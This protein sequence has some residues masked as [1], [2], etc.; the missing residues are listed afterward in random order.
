MPAWR[1][2]RQTYGATSQILHW[3]VAFFVFAMLALGWGREIAPGAWRP[4][5]IDLHKSI[6]FCILCLMMI[7]TA[8]RLYRGAPRLPEGM[9]KLSAYAAAAVHALLYG[10]LLLMP[11]SG[12]LMLS[13]AGRPAQIF[14]LDLPALMEKDRNLLPFFKELHEIAAYGLSALIALHVLAALYHHYIRKD[15]IL[16][17]MLPF[18]KRGHI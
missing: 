13:A 15:D 7:R 3:L 17:R 5:M 9:G 2:L 11:V 8:W 18:I 4:A 6:G 12:W 14:G 16:R 1:K 10:F